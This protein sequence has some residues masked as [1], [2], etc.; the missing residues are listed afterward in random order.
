[1]D[2]TEVVKTVG[3][4]TVILGVGAYV[5]RGVFGQVLSR[6][7]E[8]FKAD[9]S[10]QHDIE[11][12]RLRTDPRITASEHETQFTRLHETRMRTIAELYARLVRAHQAFDSYLSMAKFHG[13]PDDAIKGEEARKHAREF[14][15][16]FSE[17]R[18]YFEEELCRDIDEAIEQLRKAYVW[19][20]STPQ[21]LDGSITQW[22]KAALHFSE[23]F[24]PIRPKIERQFRELIGVQKAQSIGQGATDKG[25][26]PQ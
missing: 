26:L 3:T 13:E 10:A 17:E 24:P 7:L 23:H 8:K 11:I 25:L 9:L 18:I 2:W 4:T 1:L 20:T 6:D 22:S 21:Q 16:Y 12:E 19:K 14:I 5:L 15:E